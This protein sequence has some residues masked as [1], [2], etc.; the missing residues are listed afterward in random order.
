[1]F[2]ERAPCQRCVRHEE[3]EGHVV[4]GKE[5]LN[6]FLS[7]DQSFGGRRGR[8]QAYWALPAFGHGTASDPS[9]VSVEGDH[10]R[11]ERNGQVSERLSPT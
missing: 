10:G 3:A 4:S 5:P 8:R 11:V 2:G 9:P 1:M 6:T 7:R